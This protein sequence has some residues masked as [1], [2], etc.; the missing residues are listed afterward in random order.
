VVAP[1]LGFG[2]VVDGCLDRVGQLFAD[3]R[4]QVDVDF[5]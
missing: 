1:G 4:R 3:L 5:S 2:G